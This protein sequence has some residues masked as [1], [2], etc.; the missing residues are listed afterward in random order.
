MARG[1]CLPA[2]S[3]GVIRRGLAVQ[4]HPIA[5]ARQAIVGQRL[6]KSA[7]EPSET[8]PIPGQDL[9]EVSVLRSDSRHDRRVAVAR[10]QLL[11]EE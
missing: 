10:L 3:R 6:P 1:V 11:F 2:S 8:A 9:V 7:G 4:D 5:D